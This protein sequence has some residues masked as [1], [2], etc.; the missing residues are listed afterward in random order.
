MEFLQKSCQ[1]P[2]KM[3]SHIDLRVQTSSATMLVKTTRELDLLMVLFC[4]LVKIIVLESKNL[5]SRLTENVT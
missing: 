1:S 5:Q 2:V 4:F 3:P